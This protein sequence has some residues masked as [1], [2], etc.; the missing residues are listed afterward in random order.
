MEV[1]LDTFLRS[2]DIIDWQHPAIQSVAVQLT[3][4]TTL[5][6]AKRC[7]EWVRDEIYHSSDHH[8]NPV[9]CRAS[10]VLHARTGFCYAKSHLLA[11]LLRANDIPAGLCYQRVRQDNGTYCLHGLNAVY[12]P[13]FGWYRIDARG[14]KPSVNAQFTPPVEQ[15]AFM[16]DAKLGEIDLPDLYA[17]PLPVVVTALTTYTTI[18][19]LSAHLPDFDPTRVGF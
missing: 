19:E 11:A 17:D 6:T 9:T 5:E 1:P 12:L 3:S 14:N 7:Y 13:D 10:D 8:K 18:E 16:L 4:D 2:T 15:L